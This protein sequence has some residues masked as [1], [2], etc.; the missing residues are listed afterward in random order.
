MKTRTTP[1]RAAI[2]LCLALCPLLT[3]ACS[4]SSRG[5][6]KV[7]TIT[8]NEGERIAE[9]RRLAAQAQKAEDP[10]DAARLYRQA[11]ASWSDFPAA[12]NNLGV[13]HLEAG[14][15]I[16]AAEA[17]TNAAEYAAVDPRPL[18]NLGLTWERT[19]H[20]REA[21]AYYADALTRDPRYLPA[22]RG[23]IYARDRLGEADDLSLDRLRAALMQEQNPKWRKY[24]ELR[25]LEVEAELS[26]Q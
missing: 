21:A 1:A 8:I 4:S 15:Y 7:T 5:R 23:V 17:F 14:R 18:Y 19:R 16:N 13:L 11:V 12:W 9:A 6:D 22:L 26:E 25:K 3:A 20:L 24:F 2:M 10:D